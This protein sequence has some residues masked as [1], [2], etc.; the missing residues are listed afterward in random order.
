MFSGVPKRDS[1]HI[2]FE[3]NVLLSQVADPQ[4]LLPSFQAIQEAEEVLLAR[5]RDC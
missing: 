4:S 2:A 3:G 1:V 5:G